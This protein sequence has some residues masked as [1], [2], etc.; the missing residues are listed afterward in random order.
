MK[1]EIDAHREE[2]DD[3][4]SRLFQLEKIVSKERIEKEG[5]EMLLK[6]KERRFELEVGNQ[7]LET[8]NQLHREFE[9]ERKA[10][11]NEHVKQR[12][13]DASSVETVQFLRSETDAL[14]KSV[15]EE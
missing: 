12:E 3:L 7:V 2:E 5:L 1:A 9:E 15:D 6:E 4:R 14:R 8:R 11:M 10:W 13:T